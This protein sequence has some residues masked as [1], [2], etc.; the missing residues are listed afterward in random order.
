MK[1]LYLY[2]TD[3][4]CDAGSVGEGGKTGFFNIAFI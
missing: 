2:E 1:N 3:E 4:K